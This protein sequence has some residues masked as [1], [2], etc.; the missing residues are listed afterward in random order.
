MK[1]LNRLCLIAC[2]VAAS[3]TPFSPAQ[4]KLGIMVKE[5]YGLRLA[6]CYACHPKGEEKDQ[7][8]G[9]GQSLGKLLE[10][11]DVTQRLEEVK[12]LDDDDA[13]KQKVYQAAADVI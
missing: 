9:F 6:T 4:S 7:L 2:L 10:G 12:D 8:N 3:I 11:K 5:H 13:T 1:A